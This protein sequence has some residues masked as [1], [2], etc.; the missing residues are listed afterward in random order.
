M[1]LDTNEQTGSATFGLFF[2]FCSR[3]G[4]PDLGCTPYFVGPVPWIPVKEKGAV[5][6]ASVS[7]PKVNIPAKYQQ[8]LDAIRSSYLPPAQLAADDVTSTGCIGRVTG[9]AVERAIASAP[10]GMRS[11]ANHTV[12][13]VMAAAKSYGVTDPAQVSYILS[14]IQTETTMGANLTE[15]ATRNKSAPGSVFYGRGLVQ[16]TGEDNYRKASKLVGVDLVKNPE[17]ASDPE[18]SAKILVVGMR[19]GMFTG[20]KLSDYIGNGSANFVAARRIVNDSDK[21][22]A[23]ATDAQRYLSAISTTSIA[24]LKD[25]GSTCAADTV[26]AVAGGQLQQR[27]Y[28]AAIDSYGMDSSQS[29]LPGGGNVA[30]AWAVNKVL[31]QAGIPTVGDNPNLVFSVRDSLEAGRGQEI[32][33]RSVAKAGDLALALGTGNKQHIGVCMNDGCTQVLSN[34]SS[35]Q[36]FR[37]KS[38]TDFG[39]YYE[40]KSKIY[41]VTK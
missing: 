41:R 21:Q 28:Q 15:G 11:N 1:L 18:I 6:L 13:L 40:V 16:L 35:K 12:P 20:R 4:I 3:G 5:I 23:M 19:D 7:T 10:E 24:S 37:W 26:T 8:Q 2:R 30:C 36:S 17:L 34:S 33:D 9:D 14:T 39:G 22:Y 25:T 38:D 32:S 27:I 29:G 31:N